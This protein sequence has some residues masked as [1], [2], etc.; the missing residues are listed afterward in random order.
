MTPPAAFKVVHFKTF[1]C[2]AWVR[3]IVKQIMRDVSLR[4]FGA[5]LRP[6]LSHPFFRHASVSS[7]GAGDRFWLFI[8]TLNRAKKWFNS[9]NY[10]IQNWTKIFIQRIIQI[11]K[12]ISAWKKQGK[13]C[14]MGRFFLKMGSFFPQNALFI[15]F[16]YEFC[17]F[18]I[19]SKFHS[20]VQQ[21]YSLKKIFIQK[22]IWLFIQ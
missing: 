17:T 20:I 21:K 2:L 19:H 8:F 16:S 9:K 12:I 5:R 11:G 15:H 13:T 22:N 10:S 4:A 6:C 3:F 1:N 7:I 18:L 14:K